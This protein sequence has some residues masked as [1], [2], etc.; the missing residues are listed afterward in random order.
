MI[1]SRCHLHGETRGTCFGLSE[2]CGPP[3]SF[4]FGWDDEYPRYFRVSAA[5]MTET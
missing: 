5:V 1:V 2:G 3:S 4:F